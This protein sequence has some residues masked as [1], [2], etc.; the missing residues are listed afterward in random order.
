MSLYPM[1]KLP[2]GNLYKTANAQQDALSADANAKKT[3]G[4]S[5]PNSWKEAVLRFDGILDTL[6][7]KIAGLLLNW[8]KAGEPKYKK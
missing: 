1:G 3:G 2:Q 7:G 4:E 5:I 6:K 8:T